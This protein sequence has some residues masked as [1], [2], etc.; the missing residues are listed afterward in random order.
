MGLLNAFE[1]S[2]QPRRFFTGY[3]KF[4]SPPKSLGHFEAFYNHVLVNAP[5]AF[6]TLIPDRAWIF[7]D[8][9]EALS[10]LQVALQPADAVIVSPVNLGGANTGL[11]MWFG[12]FPGN[13]WLSAGDFTGL[14]V[15]TRQLRWKWLASCVVSSF[16]DIEKQGF[17]LEVPTTQLP[18][19]GACTTHNLRWC[20]VSN[21]PLHFDV[22]PTWYT[23]N[24]TTVV[25]F[26]LVD[27][28]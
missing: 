27:I 19:P 24:K 21:H 17:G 9:D 16:Q 5:V 2:L 15:V 18:W 8:D 20:F 13:I 6:Y 26:V 12:F 7:S 10:H 23:V 25:T 28:P 22:H 1:P 3:K 4:F 11:R 14:L